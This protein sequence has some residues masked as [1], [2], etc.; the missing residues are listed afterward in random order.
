MVAFG[1]EAL[2]IEIGSS[3]DRQTAPDFDAETV[4]AVYPA[5]AAVDRN[6]TVT[7]AEALSEEA[8]SSQSPC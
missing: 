6:Q 5:M 2:R 8:A 4:E 1:I 7:E 3:E